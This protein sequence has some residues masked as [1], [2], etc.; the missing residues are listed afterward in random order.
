MAGTLPI[1]IRIYTICF[2]QFHYTKA[3]HVREIPKQKG[4]LQKSYGGLSLRRMP[5]RKPGPR[6]KTLR[7]PGLRDVKNRM[8][9]S[10]IKG[11]PVPAGRF[12][13]ESAPYIQRGILGPMSKTTSLLPK[14]SIA[15][16][17]HQALLG[18]H[19]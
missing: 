8:F 9:I 1:F 6:S 14:Q 16:L 12:S 18:L 2:V 15:H 10:S 19:R 4:Y 5:E 13:P 3:Y 11:P 7:G 17:R